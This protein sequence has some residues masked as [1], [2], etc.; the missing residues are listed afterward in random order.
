MWKVIHEVP[1]H[2]WTDVLAVRAI[3]PVQ[4]NDAHTRMALPSSG[5]DVRLVASKKKNAVADLQIGLLKQG[6][7]YSTP[8]R[9]H[10]V[11][12]QEGGLR[13]WAVWFWSV[14][15]GLPLR[16]AMALLDLHGG[17]IDTKR[18]RRCSR[19]GPRLHRVARAASP[20]ASRR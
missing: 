19:I 18:V 11:T 1:I 3:A 13:F 14:V 10:G 20:W 5:D 7:G 8:P 17:V 12:F 15:A 6:L 2:A 9:N 16:L 4:A